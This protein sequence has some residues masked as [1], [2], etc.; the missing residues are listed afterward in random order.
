MTYLIFISHSYFLF[1]QRCVCLQYIILSASNATITIRSVSHNL[2]VKKEKYRFSDHVSNVNRNQHKISYPTIYD[3]T[4]FG[5]FGFRPNYYDV[6]LN[7][8]VTM[9][10]S[11]HF[12]SGNHIFSQG[13]GTE[14]YNKTKQI[15]AS[16]KAGGN[17]LVTGLQGGNPGRVHLLL[18]QDQVY[19]CAV[20][21]REAS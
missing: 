18:P 4:M 12:P 7:D 17:H 13:L 14:Y 5:E 6:I 20:C 11:W 15:E 19:Q 1:A 16:T 3:M 10:S 2:L 8:D 9:T 21:E